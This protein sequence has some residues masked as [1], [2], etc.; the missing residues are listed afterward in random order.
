MSN[1]ANLT[2]AVD[3]PPHVP[4]ALVYDFDMFND[5]AYVREPHARLLDLIEKAPPVF[6]TPRFGGHWIILTHA[7]NFKAARDTETFSSEIVP[8]AMVKEILANMPPGTPHVP[9]PI[10]V[11]VDPPEHT[12]Y[13]QPLQR[14]FS[15]K[16]IDALKGDIRALANRLIDKIEARGE[17]E[18]MSEVA[19]PLPVQI[20]LK[21]MGL[22]LE[23]QAEYR[24]LVVEHLSDHSRDQS[25]MIARMQRIAGGMRD[26]MLE[27][28]QHPRND[29]ISL[30]WNVEIDGQPTTLDDMENYGVLLFIAGLDTVM[31]AMG[32]GLR[33]LAMDVPLQEQL[34]ANP[35]LIGEA[36][37]ELLRRY[38]FVATVRRVAKDTVFEGAEMKADERVM[39]F[40]PAANLDAKEFPDPAKFDINREK[41]THITFN[42]GP[43]RCLGSH[44]ARLELH[45]IYELFL[46]R[47]PTFRL[48]PARPPA[49]QCGY[50]AGV[51]SLNLIWQ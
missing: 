21:M 8:H 25:R 48:D 20:F 7:A 2:P 12:K 23:R 24:T 10:P 38:G 19:E 51:K 36:T 5:P 41:K 46:S 27:R 4:D 3:R 47:L 11:T 6:W 29:I 50:I 31:N 35:Q 22:P 14:I 40:L 43:H 26:I 28:R 33:H 18:F 44:L 1:D 30:L 9:I 32:H 17:C 42:A 49:Y 13:R 34:R 16:V 39:M 45:T 37:E 15:P